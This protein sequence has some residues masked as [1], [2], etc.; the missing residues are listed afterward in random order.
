MTLLFYIIFVIIIFLIFKK[1]QKKTIEY[2]I[3]G[4]NVNIR[5]E[6][7]DIQDSAQI[8]LKLEKI[9]DKIV[10][11]FYESYPN[12]EFAKRLITN[13]NKDNLQ[14]IIYNKNNGDTSYTLDKEEIYVCIRDPKNSN[15]HEFNDIL[16]VCIHELA[17]VGS[18]SIGHTDE[19]WKN[20]EILLKFCI[21]K[22][23]YKNTNYCKNP[24]SYC[25]IKIDSSPTCY[26]S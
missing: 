22:G 16:F 20:F 17:H 26:N 21:K 11:D 10:K 12:S 8:F 19:F 23:Y 13:F 6:Y 9:T 2:H 4:E 7:K 24:V 5:P 25:G 15:I 14:E 3:N 18:K 1:L